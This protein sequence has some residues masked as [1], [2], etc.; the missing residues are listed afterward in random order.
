MT[1]ALK[2]Y[3]AGP[4]VFLP[5]AESVL[6]HKKEICAR[7]GLIGVSPLDNDTD[8][9]GMTL[10]AWAMQISQGNEDTM[11]ACD[12]V[13]ANMTPF[14]GPSMDVGTAFEM[15]YMRAC[16]K[17]VFGYSN[18]PAPYVDRVSLFFG[19]APGLALRRAPDGRTIDPRGLTVEAFGL[20]D[21]LMMI[22][23]VDACGGMVHVPPSP[24]QDPDRDMVSFEQAVQSAQMLTKGS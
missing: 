2:V 21:N 6:D 11:D 22:G 10:S 16:K 1:S 4:D 24:V 8:G 3:L 14:R 18:D 7:Y 12:L 9:A 20:T 15:G 5:D 13:I 23:A 17:P 19:E